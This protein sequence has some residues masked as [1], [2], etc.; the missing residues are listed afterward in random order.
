MT[1]CINMYGQLNLYLLVL[2][3]K[4]NTKTWKQNNEITIGYIIH[5]YWKLS[6]PFIRLAYTR[7]INW[8]YG[9]TATT[10]SYN[11]IALQEAIL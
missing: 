3:T 11:N 4:E 5:L 7:Q 9:I 6:L 1:L 2:F 10:F 8:V